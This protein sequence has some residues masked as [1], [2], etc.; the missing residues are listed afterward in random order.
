MANTPRLS[1][2]NQ[3][4]QP[5]VQ[6]SVV[7]Q[8][9]VQEAPNWSGG[10]YT[11]S[12]AS[13]AD[14]IVQWGKNPKRRDQQ[15]RD[16]WPTESFLA[17]A[18][19]SVSMRNASYD[20]EIQHSSQAVINSVVDMF[21][22]AIAGDRFG[23]DPFIKKFCQDLYCQDNGGFIEL[24]RDPGQDANSKF[25]GPMAP[26]IGIGNLDAG[27]CQRTGNIETPVLY[28]DRE[29][30]VHKLRWYEVIPFS[31]FPSSIEKM[32]GVGY[33]A[34]TRA[35]R[36]AQIIRSVLLFKDEEV[37][38]TNTKKI[39]IIGGVGRTQIDDA[40]KRTI[41]TAMNKGNARYVEHT[42]LSSLD[43]SKPVSAIT[44]DLAG[45][46]EDFNYDQEMQ[47]Y[48]AGLALDF[49]VDYQ[50]FAPLPGGNIGSGS[51]STM[52]HLKASGKGPRNWM[53][54]LT[55]A[56]KYYGVIPRGAEIIFNDKNEQEELEKQEIR[57]K[58][59]EESAIAVNAKIMTPQ[60][61]LKSLVRRRI[62]SQKDIDNMPEDWWKKSE[63]SILGE[64]KNQPV[65]NRGGNTIAQDV[66][67]QDTGKPNQ[68][69]GDRL[70]KLFGR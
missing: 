34:V 27:Q 19:T 6:E 5:A 14:A 24:I 68:T 62:Y 54:S 49:G 41:E 10:F 55:S 65:G 43:P 9:K 13:S 30:K 56:F 29:G 51:Q 15:L 60:A 25:K 42:I 12:L 18:I 22:S 21:S 11:L 67:R 61:A 4:P 20:W 69:V 1:S 47:W 2:E 46:P 33:C 31:E 44:V 3:F 40:V 63:D 64:N 50:E 48:I 53:N 38:G 17:G 26:V 32:N 23:W 57:T 37:S 70:R 16:F 39:N 36:L 28:T 8:P 45:L 66:K 59:L 58:A 7:I 35:L 52:L